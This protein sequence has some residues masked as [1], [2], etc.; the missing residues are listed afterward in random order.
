M[1][2]LRIVTA[3]VIIITGLLVLPLPLPFGLVLI[4][5]G[6]MILAMDL[7]PIC[8]MLQRLRGR[9]PLMSESLRK[10]EPHVGRFAGE[11]LKKTTPLAESPSTSATLDKRTSK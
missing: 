8:R 11:I 6:M 4:F 5:I 7:P 2:L 10:M 1:L 3:V 9:Y